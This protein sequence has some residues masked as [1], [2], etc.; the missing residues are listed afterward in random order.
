MK[1]TKTSSAER[2][3]HEETQLIQ[4]LVNCAL[5]CESCTA[6]CLSEAD[7]TAM[8]RCIQLS[9]DCAD[10]CF[11]AS[12]LT[13]R[14]SELTEHMLRVCEEACRICADECRK[15]DDEHCKISAEACESCANTCHDFHARLKV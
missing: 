1:N 7:V 11:L 6:G 8:T 15:H 2:L 10:V 3:T 5:A 4:E 12:R 13:M 14:D 9:R